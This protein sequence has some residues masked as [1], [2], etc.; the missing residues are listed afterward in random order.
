MIIYKY[1]QNNKTT[2]KRDTRKIKMYKD[3]PV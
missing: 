3:S 1:I 2:K